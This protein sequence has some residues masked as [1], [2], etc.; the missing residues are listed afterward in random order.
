[1]MYLIQF[2]MLAITGGLV[3]TLTSDR[4]AHQVSR[5]IET[6]FDFIEYKLA[7]RTY[8]IKTKE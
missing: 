1:M 8:V 7:S 5:A 6:M 2:S 3:L 4:F